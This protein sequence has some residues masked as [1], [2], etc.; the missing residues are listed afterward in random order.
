MKKTEIKKRSLSEDF[1]KKRPQ[2]KS[3]KKRRVTNRGFDWYSKSEVSHLTNQDIR[4]SNIII[5]DIGDI[6]NT[7]IT[8][9]HQ[10]KNKEI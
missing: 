3:K 1:A 7:D 10:P 6:S 8:K 2:R 4:L 9:H 5:G